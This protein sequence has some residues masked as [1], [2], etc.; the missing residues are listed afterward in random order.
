MKKNDLDLVKVGNAREKKL[1]VI[2]ENSK[3]IIN[4]LYYIESVILRLAFNEKPDATRHK[5]I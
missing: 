3:R 2:K 5:L 1:T 4:G